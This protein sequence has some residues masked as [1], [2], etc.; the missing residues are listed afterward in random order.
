MTHN[1][2]PIAGFEPIP[3]YTLRH[4][5]GAGGYGEVWLADAPG[6]LQKAVKLIFGTMDQER[7]SSELRSLQRVRQVHHPFILS[8]ERIE[9]V[10]NR[11]II[12]TELAECS[13]VER[14]QHFRRKGLPGI[15][16]DLLLEYMRDAADALDFLSQKHDLQHLDVKPGNLLIIA[17]RI[18]VADFGLIKEL[19]DKNQSLIGGL[20]P[21][22]AAPEIFDGRPDRRSDQYSLAI[23]YQE[24]LAGS[25]PFT[26][27]TTAELARQ[28]LNS[29]PDLEPLA[30]ADRPVIAR[31]L[32]KNPLDRFSSCRQLVEQ[33]T[34]ARGNVIVPGTVGNVNASTPSSQSALA[35]SEKRTSTSSDAGRQNFQKS[36]DVD[37]NCQGWQAPSCLFIGLG[38]TGCKTLQ[39]LHQRIQE[40]KDSVVR[41]DMHG[42]LAIDTDTQTLDELNFSDPARCLPQ[43]STLQIQL[44]RPQE[45]RNSHP[46]LFRS[47]SR[48]WLYNIPRSLKTEGVRPLATLAFLDHYAQ[49][50][51]R[52]FT[53]VHD[54]I[55]RTRDD[56]YCSNEPLKVYIVSSAHGGTGG[57]LFSEI[58]YLVREAFR[59]FS[60]NNYRLCGQLSL[61]QTIGNNRSILASAAGLACLSELTNCMNPDAII[62]PIHFET[63]G[64]YS[65]QQRPFDWVSMIDGGLHGN[66]TDYLK[67]QE[68]IA[69]SIWLDSQTV[70]GQALQ[71]ARISTDQTNNNWLRTSQTASVQS[72]I[73]TNAQHVSKLCCEAALR[74]V[75]KYFVGDRTGTVESE[76]SEQDN[77]TNTSDIPLTP[78]AIED[79]TRR[80]SVQLRI[81]PSEA[82]N[83]DE[84]LTPWT[85]R[86]STNHETCAAK[87]QEDLEV[88]GAWL[89]N[90]IRMRV[91]N[92]K[93]LERLQLLAIG[94]IMDN[95]E[96][97]N[98]DLQ[99]HLAQY[100]FAGSITAIHERLRSYLRQL[101]D[102]CMQQ[103]NK[104]QSVARDFGRKISGWSD[105][106]D[107]ER[108]MSN[109]DGALS[110]ESLSGPWKQ[111]AVRAVAVL[112]STLHR[113]TS[114][115]LKVPSDLSTAVQDD[116]EAL[117]LKTLLSV[118]RDVVERFAVEFR[119][120]AVDCGN[121][122]EGGVPLSKLASFFPQLSQC[123]GDVYRLLVV[124]QD[125]LN[126]LAIALEQHK[127][128]QT[129]TLVPAVFGQAAYVFNEATNL[130]LPNLI[131]L[132]WRPN[133]TTY[134]LAERLRTRTDVDWPSAQKLT[135]V[136][137]LHTEVQMPSI[138][139][140]VD[141]RTTYQH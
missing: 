48:R 50:K 52:V 89:D 140:P 15:P 119:A 87:L 7:A 59:N 16:R 23:V 98:T 70:V 39:T 68:S 122:D 139:M 94:R 41:G 19:H 97:E 18:K 111:V 4:R 130:N 141:D 96:Q 64:E 101:A 102:E 3:G 77:V 2:P 76:L 120:V 65:N 74:N 20:T 30:P 73:R 75:V 133:P 13:L 71:Q 132:L 38:E 62:P 107:A 46:E 55:E 92:W 14:Y 116:A 86:L 60:W 40:D 135:E 43:G 99:Q 21:T 138:D 110:Y 124:A 79:I 11:V 118:S 85:R 34:R 28:H 56:E 6:G 49:I 27:R 22:Y 47:I 93:Q 137:G 112:E 81:E 57:A 83:E 115:A 42:W 80:L 51:R 17:D 53:L 69:N 105:S 9:V 117:N 125:Q 127:L 104:R 84:F 88:V 66:Q 108:A 78:N 33:L 8:L 123:G 5:L 10:D 72:S 44:Y 121:K 36:L 61:A 26:G 32:S 24:L 58:A 31:A 1:L 100:E 103:F 95:A 106:L 109:N 29:S 45:Y 82:V 129:T 128:I 90:L 131:N 113:E 134:Q 136:A 91:Y 63:L 54:L 35:T 12:V 37:L 25:L 114:V 67:T 126:S